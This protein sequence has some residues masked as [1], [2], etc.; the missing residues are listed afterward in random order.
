MS[1]TESQQEPLAVS[2]IATCYGEQESVRVFYDRLVATLAPLTPTVEII[3]V[4]D[5][6]R[7]AT[8]Q[9]LRQIAAG[10]DRVKL[11]EIARNAGQWA[12]MT[13][14][15]LHATHPALVL[16]D[17]DLEIAPEELPA[18]FEAYMAGAELVS[19]HRCGRADS[20]TRIAI[21]KIGNLIMRALMGIRL[22]DLGSGMKII[23]RRL[24]DRLHLSEHKI[25]NPFDVFTHAA[26]VENVF[27]QFHPR[28]GGQSHW[29]PWR[30]I[31]QFL[32]A[33]SQHLHRERRT[34]LIVLRTLLLAGFIGSLGAL[35][36]IFADG[37]TAV[38]ILPLLVAAPL[39]GVAVVSSML[40]VLLGK[41]P[42]EQHAGVA[43]LTVPCSGES[44]ATEQGALTDAQA[45]PD[46]CRSSS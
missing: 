22:S 40:F 34:G 46:E 28:H 6:S 17:V 11:I 35:V 21:S 45:T 12:A 37:S 14:G 10:D 33:F 39:T 18:F 42:L 15:Y 5:G 25:L 27:V 19:A 20:A 41:K 36:A 24:F 43:T 7:D 9:I 26:R 38:G 16:V 29:P 4:D 30:V 44:V 31:S 23:D 8:P 32:R 13:W 2:V 3:F 1:T